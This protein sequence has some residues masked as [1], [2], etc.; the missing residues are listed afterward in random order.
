MW[1]HIAK[2]T[3]NENSFELRVKPGIFETKPPLVS[4]LPRSVLGSWSTVNCIASPPFDTTARESPTLAIHNFVPF[5]RM[6]VTAVDPPRPRSGLWER[7]ASSVLSYAFEM[8]LSGW[9]QNS[10]YVVR[11]RE[12]G[13]SSL[14]N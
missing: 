1:M 7:I 4:I 2:Q 10:S 12:S 8:A 9:D 13:Y 11:K 14:W 5:M 6:A 3:H